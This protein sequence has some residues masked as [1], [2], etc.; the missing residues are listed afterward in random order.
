M[1]DKIIEVSGVITKEERLKSLD[2][3]I[4]HNTQ[5]LETIDPFGGYYNDDPT[6]NIPQ[7]IYMLT[8]DRD[9]MEEIARA[10]QNI[11]KYF[12]TEF[13]ASKAELEFYNEKHTAIRLYDVYDY[14]HI[15]E[16]QR[17]YQS[18]GIKFIH[19]NSHIDVRAI[20]KL[21]KTFLLNEFKPG[22]YQNLSNS[23]MGYF[24]L[25]NHYSWKHFV[26][27]VKRVKNN[28][29]GHSFDAAYGVF[30][31]K[32]GMQEVVRIYTP[33]ITNEFILEVKEAFEKEIERL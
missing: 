25:K 7:S 31:R 2:S 6:Q 17:A 23:P 1:S 18:E 22:I 32:G 33:V 19:K 9:T 27:I 8:K 26:S 24:T 12:E 4:M 11:K 16:L 10:T 3:N 28:W 21:C 20:I 30:F 15:E 29:D 14:Q 13:D 5:V